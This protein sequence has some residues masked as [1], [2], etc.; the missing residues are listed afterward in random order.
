MSLMNNINHRNNLKMTPNIDYN[1]IMNVKHDEK[2]LI[3]NKPCLTDIK[4]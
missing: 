2:N 1:F 4:R 3:Q